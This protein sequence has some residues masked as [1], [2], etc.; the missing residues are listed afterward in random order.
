M[1]VGST[2]TSTLTRDQIVEQ[3]YK[4]V[5]VVAEGENL[6]NEQLTDGVRALQSLVRQIDASGKWLHATDPTPTS[7]TLV[8]NQW[9]YTS[10]ASEIPTDVRQID[11]AV[12]RDQQANDWPLDI[13][14]REQFAR[15][16]NKLE[17]GD[18]KCVYLT[19]EDSILGVHTL[20]VTP[21]LTSVQSQSIAQG[22]DGNDYSCI[23]SHTAAS[24]NYPITGANY[25]QYWT[26]AG[27]TAA[28]WASGTSYTA[29]EQILLWYRRPLYE[30]GSSAHNPDFPPEWTRHLIYRLA[31][32]LG[33]NNSVPAER[34]ATLAA[35][36]KAA[37]DD[38]FPETMRPRS[39][40]IHGKGL[41]F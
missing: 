11:V 23:R 25:L 14:T 29:P 7:V 21:M 10:A 27:T 16:N 31:V 9:T 13:L 36:A 1:A 24:G 19:Q 33:N 20:H 38:L 34:I 18:P 30:F 40:K 35:I 6:T 5:G 8:A 17:S 4:K 22:S 2:F 12:Y 26:L 15:I 3:A 28:A 32:D 39:N 41:D 37:Y